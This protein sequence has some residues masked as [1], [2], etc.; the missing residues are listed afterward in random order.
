MHPNNVA[1][2]VSEVMSKLISE[3]FREYEIMCVPQDNI[4]CVIR[5]DFK[6]FFY[7]H[8]NREGEIYYTNNLEIRSTIMEL[9]WLRCVML[10]PIFE[11][12]LET[13]K[14]ITKGK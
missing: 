10:E 1:F 5:Y 8:N 3:Q 13:F 9:D 2:E 12:F 14:S 7:L 4:V 11:M 6:M